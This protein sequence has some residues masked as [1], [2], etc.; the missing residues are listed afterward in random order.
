MQYIFFS[1]ILIM[2]LIVGIIIG[3]Y[4]VNLTLKLTNFECYK[5]KE[6]EMKKTGVTEMSNTK[7]I[8]PDIMDEWFNG[9]GG[10]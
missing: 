3:M 7:N 10:E 6:D 9:G 1:T 8:T 2:T 5:K 4:L